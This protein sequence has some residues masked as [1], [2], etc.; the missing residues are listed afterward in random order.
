MTLAALFSGLETSPIGEFVKNRGATF[1]SIEAVH[2]LAWATLGGAVLTMDLRL[3][4]VLLRDVPSNTVC[5]HGH[6]IFKI[7]LC[8]SLISGFFMLSGVAVKCY[9]SFYY[10]VKMIAL[11]VG[12]LFVFAVRQPL[13]KYEHTQIN[14]VLLKLVGLSSM[15]V[16][17]LV[18]ASGRW[19][20][21][22]G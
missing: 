1:A 12:I 22:S 20:G 4:N 13:L 10:W 14:P 3:M 17:T 2:L 16:W 7:A 21:F 8:V 18:A 9:H 15:S 11:A 19:I 5:R 6:V